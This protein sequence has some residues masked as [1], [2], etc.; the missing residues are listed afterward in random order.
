[1]AASKPVLKTLYKEISRGEHKVVTYQE[2]IEVE[3][4]KLR[5]NIKSDPHKF[6]CE[7]SVQV[8]SAVSLQWN[9]LATIHYASMRT[10]AELG[11]QP[12][13]SGVAECFVEDRNN[14]VRQASAVL[15]FDLPK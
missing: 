6:Q 15:G 4:Y 3:A 11:Y 12:N 8:F 14:L 7:A 10:P 13:N 1:M 9:E 2:M 5:V